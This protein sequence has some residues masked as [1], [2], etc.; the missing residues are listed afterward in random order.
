MRTCENCGSSI[1]CGCQDRIASNG[2]RVCANCITSYEAKIK[3]EA[4]IAQTT[5]T[6]NENPP[7]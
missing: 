3:L 4:L 6:Q 2:K 1:T 5:T 7:S